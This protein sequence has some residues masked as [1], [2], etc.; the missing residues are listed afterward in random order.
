MRN[1]L[2]IYSKFAHEWWQQDGRYFRSLQNLTPFRLSLISELIG[3][4]RDKVVLDLGCG[5]GLIS[6]PLL[7]LGAQVTGIDLSAE[8]I[9]V[10]TAAANGRGCFKVGDI[11]SLDI[12]T[13]SVDCVIIADVLDH[14]PHFA[15]SLREASRVLKRNGKLFVGTL[16]RTCISHFFTITLG[17]TLGFIPKGTHDAKLFIKPNELIETAKL[18]GLSHLHTQGEWPLLIRTILDGA[19]TLRKSSST[20]IAYSAVFLKE[21]HA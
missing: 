20:A 18:F 7:D 8:S 6:V 16:N 17:E 10:A 9:A 21:A 1:D 14:V 15:Q 19:I 2:T 5:G 4:L 13:D 11:C 3:D 12:P